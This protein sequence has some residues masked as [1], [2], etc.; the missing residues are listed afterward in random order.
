[1]PQFLAPLINVQ[2]IDANG[3]PL[4]AGEIEIYLAG[5]STP[6]ASYSDKDG[7]IPNTWPLV[8][9][10][11][12]LNS[13]GA[14]WLP[15]GTA[16]KFVVKNEFG[17][18]QRT[19]DNVTG[20]NDTSIT[21]DQWILFPGPPTYISATS[22]SVVGDQTPTLQ[23]G[24]RLKSI[25]TA[26]TVYST[27]VSSVYGA[28][29]TTVTV[30]NSSGGALDA[31]LS[32]VSYGLLSVDSGSIPFLGSAGS[33]SSR[34]RIINGN[35][36]VNQRGVSG[37]VVLAAGAYGHDR[38]KAGAGGCTYTFAAS[39]NDTVLTITAGSLIQVVE[40]AN[41]EGGSCAMSWFG[42]AT[43]KIG[44]GATGASG[45][46]GTATAGANLNVE[47]GLGTLSRVQLEPGSVGTPFE[48]RPYGLE[49]SLCQRYYQPF[50]YFGGTTSRA[51]LLDFTVS[52]GVQMRATPTVTNFA[53]GGGSASAAIY[54]G[55]AWFQAPVAANNATA[56]GLVGPGVLLSYA[57]SGAVAG[58]P[59]S[60]AIAGTLSAEL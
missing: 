44:A 3:D 34:N 42:T 37:S 33:T 29:N 36:A 50:N 1:M 13:Q 11:L 12:G 57:Y 10:T 6:V 9:N 59:G 32:Q 19:I 45:V 30:Q 53:S 39:G 41:V 15:G 5:S 52:T 43:G 40:G 22:F 60:I 8:L 26:G 14:V 56:T 55:T 17:L 20:I 38:W 24:R 58:W 25:N 21:V 51:N 23:A 54:N 18:V 48:R 31:G 7:L 35:F 16:Y 2:Q 27:I 49:L 28:P 47:F 46:T 4:T